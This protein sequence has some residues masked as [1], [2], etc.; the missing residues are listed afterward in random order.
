MTL[1]TIALRNVK[2]SRRRS[3]LASL[4]IALSTLLCIFLVGF[5]M[6]VLED[7]ENMLLDYSTGMV[8]VRDSRFYQH[9]YLN[10]VQY[11]VEDERM[12]REKAWEVE[13][14]RAVVSRISLQGRM[15]FGD[16]GDRQ[17]GPLQGL[18]IRFEEEVMDLEGML[19]LGR[20]PEEGERGVVIGQG[21]FEKR[22]IALGEILTLQTSTAQRSLNA[23]SFPVT[24]VFAAP[25]VVMGDWVLLPLSW[26]QRLTRMEGGASEVLLYLDDVKKAD[27]GARAWGD[28]LPAPLETKVYRDLNVLYN[29]MKVGRLVYTIMAALFVLLGGTVVINTMMMLVY[30]RVREIGLLGALGLLPHQIARLFFLEALIVSLSSA[31]LGMVLGGALVYYTGQVGIP[32]GEAVFMEGIDLDYPTVFRPVL[33][34]RVLFV[35]G[36]I[37]TIMSAV[38]ASIPARR[39]SKME[40]IRALSN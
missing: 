13:G 29:Y 31:A 11:Y 17:E 19:R 20:Y 28:L 4:A 30:E 38:V 27:A 1:F 34:L 26:A 23:V 7:Y 40:P 14:F 8:Q 22:G 32:M 25:N 37:A 21:L 12:V 24:G 2:G 39:V 10:P 9:E 5:V 36:L 15:I 18:G 3:F 6:G 33:D 35:S 16:R